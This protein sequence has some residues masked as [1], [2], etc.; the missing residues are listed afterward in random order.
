MAR[1]GFS[2]HEN[3]SISWVFFGARAKPSSLR[4]CLA[5]GISK[6]NGVLIIGQPVSAIRQFGGWALSK[7]V[8]SKPFGFI[9]YFPFHTPQR[10]PGFTQTLQSINGRRLVRE[11][12]GLMRKRP[13]VLC[14][15]SPAQHHLVGQ[16]GEKLSIYL[17]VD[18]R[19]LKVTG[20]QIPGE[21]EAEKKLL[22]KV[23]KVICVSE[24]L[25]EVL[26]ERSPDRGSISI[27]VLPNG[28]DERL[29]DP[30]RSWGKPPALECIPR[31][32]ILVAGHISERI[33]WD[34]IAAASVLRPEWTWV[35]LGPA[36]PG[37]I[38]KIH[39]L[40]KSHAV[41][42]PPVTMKEVPSW[43]MHC[44]ACAIPYRL[45]SFTLASN[46]LKAFEYLAMGA[47]ILS[48]RIPSLQ[49][50]DR[51]IGWT[52]EGEGKSYALALEK[53]EDQ[54]NSQ[55]LRTIRQQA[56]IGDSRN[57]RVEQF[58]NIVFA[59]TKFC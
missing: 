42:H 47:P 18:D 15:D 55:D 52:N 30:N 34:G 4:R 35:F 50:Y 33:D 16:F 48:T 7:R 59:D 27:Q 24:P 40:L 19:T 29:F 45:N 2:L 57:V 11:V 37:I 8:R 51:L 46:P 54:K 22:E 56:V 43:I 10:I 25:A 20:D 9:E 6:E 41:W 32:R 53:I 36:D 44:D 3:S 14:Y 5:E 23:D 38:E 58:R 17:A 31:P 28:Y 49:R 39:F 26:R 1:P 12:L 13:I 21:L